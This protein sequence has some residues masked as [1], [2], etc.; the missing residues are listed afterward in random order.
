MDTQINFTFKLRSFL[1]VFGD[2]GRVQGGE[3][4]LFLKKVLLPSLQVIP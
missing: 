4:N 3:K 2:E 1:K